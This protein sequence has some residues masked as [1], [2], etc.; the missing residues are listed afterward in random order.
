MLI[1][2]S[3]LILLITACQSA[4]SF[5]KQ[6]EEFYREANKRGCFVF[7]IRTHFARLE[8]NIAGYC[9]SSFGI[10]LN[11]TKWKDMGEYQK[12]ELVFHELGHCV[13]GLEHTSLGLMAPSMH[14]EDEL[15]LMWPKYVE[16]LF[17]DCLTL[18][19]MINLKSSDKSGTDKQP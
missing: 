19:K 14:S 9:V 15:E 4:P 3:L 12:R 5:E 16:L 2:S 8:E 1:I 17:A 10:L 6:T 13:L 7:P 18:E 11:E